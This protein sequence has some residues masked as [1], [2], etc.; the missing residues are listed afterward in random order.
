MK[1]ITVRDEID[2]KKAIDEHIMS[3]KD[4]FYL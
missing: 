4:I 2:R 1:I 3:I